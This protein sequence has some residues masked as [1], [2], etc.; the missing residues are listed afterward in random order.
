MEVRMILIAICVASVCLVGVAIF[1]ISRA[2]EQR[3]FLRYSIEAEDLHALINSEQSVV[4]LDVRLPLDL[5]ADSE[6]IPGAVRIPPKEILANPGV[7]PVDK[8]A[9]V[10]CTCPSDKTSRSILKRALALNIRRIKFLRGGLA[11]WKAKGFPVEPYKQSF[12][13]DVA[14]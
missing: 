11:G 7:F 6:I 13:L 8:N 9:V 3:E 2:K 4:V 12:R 5:L 10:Y 14:G 1:L